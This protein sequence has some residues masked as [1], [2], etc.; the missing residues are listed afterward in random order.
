[1]GTESD[2]LYDISESFHKRLILFCVGFLV[3]FLPEMSKQQI[4]AKSLGSIILGN[5]CF[6]EKSAKLILSTIKVS[7]LIAPERELLEIEDFSF[8]LTNI[9]HYYPD[10]KEDKKIA[11]YEAE[12]CQ[13]F[14]ILTKKAQKEFDLFAAQ[15]KSIEHRFYFLND[16]LECISKVRYLLST[17]DSMPKSYENKGLL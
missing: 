2:K 1:M 7:E 16:I 4:E 5:I 13:I 8:C 14:S 10:S 6:D 15:L 12:L 11:G 17:S 9:M 3:N